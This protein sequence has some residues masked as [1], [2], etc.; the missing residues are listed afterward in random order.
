MLESRDRPVSAQIEKE[1][2]EQH[3]AD[4]NPNPDT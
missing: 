4:E 3:Q 1:R 2:K